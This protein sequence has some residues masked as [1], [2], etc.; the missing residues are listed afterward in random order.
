MHHRSTLRQFVR[1]ILAATGLLPAAQWLR[2]SV[3]PPPQSSLPTAT[4]SS[5]PSAAVIATSES[6]AHKEPPADAAQPDYAA[7][8][9]AEI[10]TFVDDEVVHDLPSIFHYWS[11]KY[12]LPKIQTFGF[13]HPDDF[14]VKQ[15][16]AVMQRVAA[17]TYRFVSVGAGNCDTEVRIAK[18]LQQSGHSNF[19][20]ECLDLNETMLERGRALAL[21]EGCAA[22]VLPVRADFNVWQ[23]TQRYQAVI[24]NQSLHHVMNLEGLFDAIDKAIRPLDGVL[25]TSDMIGRN[26][27]QRWPEAL[28]VIEEIWRTLPEPYKYNHQ[29]K[30]CDHQ[31]VNWDCSTDGFEG[32]RAQDILP[33]LVDKFHF[34]LFVP[35][36]NVISPF[37]DRGY[38]HNYDANSEADRSRIDEIHALDEAGMTA[39]TLKPTQMFAV[40]ATSDR[41]PARHPVGMSPRQCVRVP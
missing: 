10:A 41:R 15:L 40:L 13:I 11:N 2:R 21:H 36:S 30:R 27:H 18:A 3:L 20:I 29:L 1:T 32:I 19:V 26:G 9:K 22:Q 35:F 28:A 8:V 38:G 12:L 16:I 24:A 5:P 37:I 33:L 4:Q 25:I 17:P 7:R 23:P 34:E 39:G 14:F 6:P 31:F